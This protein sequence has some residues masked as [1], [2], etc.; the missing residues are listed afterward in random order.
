MMADETR[1]PQKAIAGTARILTHRMELLL[2]D[3]RAIR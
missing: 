3:G 1:W 2:H